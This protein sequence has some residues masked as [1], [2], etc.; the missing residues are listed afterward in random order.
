MRIITGNCSSDW[1][2]VLNRCAYYDFY[3][4]PTYTVLEA[5]LAGGQAKLFVHEEDKAVIALPLIV[6]PLSTVEG[7][8]APVSASYD[9]VSVYGYGGP[10][11]NQSWDDLKFFERFSLALQN[12]FNAL[13]VITAFSR[14]HPVIE[15]DA[16]LR[17]GEIISLG[18]TVSID[19]TLPKEEQFRRYRRDHRYG[20]PKAVNK[21]ITVLHDEDW[22]YFESFMALYQATM[23]RVKAD[24]RY[25]FGKEYFNRLREALG[26][27]LHLFVA[28]FDERVISASMFTT[29]NG[30]V[31]YHLSGSSPDEMKHAASKLIIDR[32]REWAVDQGNRVFHLGGGLGSKEDSLFLYK[33]GFSPLRH[34][35]K[36]WRHI[37]DRDR[38]LL[39]VGQRRDWLSNRGLV[40][41]DKHFFPQYR[42]SGSRSIDKHES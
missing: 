30:I 2:D 15:N 17:I 1:L 18:E 37:V 19:L 11:T 7:I 33:A 16:G 25:F 23:H 13:G 4:L 41:S 21:G 20:I 22:T 9:A 14:M 29:M 35:F 36:I 28:L 24:A 31:Q 32:V 26:S 39:A 6:R 5:E 42:D 8:K 12:E 40:F 10:I 34:R 27:H 3:H 38:Y